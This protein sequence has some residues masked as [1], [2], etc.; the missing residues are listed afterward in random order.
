MPP[1]KSSQ[2]SG[3]VPGPHCRVGGKVSLGVSQIYHLEKAIIPSCPSA[4]SSVSTTLAQ[5]QAGSSSSWCISIFTRESS[6]PGGNGPGNKAALYGFGP[7]ARFSIAT[8]RAASSALAATTLRG[9]G[10]GHR[11]CETI[12]DEVGR[13]KVGTEKIKSSFRGKSEE[14]QSKVVFNHRFYM[15]L[16]SHLMF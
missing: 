8:A 10:V 2:A 1:K 15:C 9:I 14:Y 3:F 13:G 6:P 16:G 7:Y 12:Y 11:A 5:R 4:S